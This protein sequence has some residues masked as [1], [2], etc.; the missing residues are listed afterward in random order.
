MVKK[1]TQLDFKEMSKRLNRFGFSVE[2]LWVSLCTKCIKGTGMG[3]SEGG[4][5]WN[6]VEFFKNSTIREMVAFCI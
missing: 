2:T 3:G 5:M 1:G 4:R 6:W